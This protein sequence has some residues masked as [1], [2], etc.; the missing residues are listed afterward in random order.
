MSFDLRISYPLGALLCHFTISYLVNTVANIL[1]LHRHS[2]LRD[3][4]RER[5]SLLKLLR[6][7]LGLLGVGDDEVDGILRL[8]Q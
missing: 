6:L 7:L 5:D 4:G 1:H 2:S 3:R 8:L